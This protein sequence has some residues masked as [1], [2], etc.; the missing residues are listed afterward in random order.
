MSKIDLRKKPRCPICGGIL[1][2][3]GDVL[4]CYTF[5]CTFERPKTDWEKK[6]LR[7]D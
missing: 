4:Y 3:T 6:W 2:G 1:R 7:K 5:G